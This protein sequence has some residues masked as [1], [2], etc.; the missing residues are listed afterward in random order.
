MFTFFH[1]HFLPDIVTEHAW[2]WSLSGSGLLAR[3]KFF[4]LT[5]IG[6]I[7]LIWQQGK[8]VFSWNAHMLC[9]LRLL[10]AYTDIYMN[11]STCAPTCALILRHPNMLIHSCSSVVWDTEITFF[12]CKY[13]AKA[14]ESKAC[15]QYCLLASA[16]PTTSSFWPW[17]EV[18]TKRFFL[19]NL[20]VHFSLEP[21]PPRPVSR[22]YSHI[23]IHTVN[24]ADFLSCNCWWAQG[25]ATTALRE[26][27]PWCVPLQS[28]FIKP[29]DRPET[30]GGQL[31]WD[32]FV[33]RWLVSKVSRWTE[34]TLCAF[35]MSKL[36]LSTQPPLPGRAAPVWEKTVLL[37]PRHE[38][39]KKPI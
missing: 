19:V 27:Q 26:R 31:D 23:L 21:P 35:S 13:L 16:C 32:S 7:L 11:M 9:R 24:S 2:Y 28:N 33:L 30:H 3:Y 17:C 4:S 29:E 10:C 20:S 18:P 38:V 25:Q 5:D 15:R 34:L 37:V 36:R 14:W 8:G 12:I 1:V 39:K 22:Y 6:P